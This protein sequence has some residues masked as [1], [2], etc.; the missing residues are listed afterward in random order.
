MDQART[1][2]MDEENT[3]EWG[4]GFVSA[5]NSLH[6]LDLPDSLLLKVLM[7][8]P[9]ES[10]KSVSLTC[11]RF[12]RIT[13]D[14]QLWKTLFQRDFKISR[15]HPMHPRACA[16]RTEY[17]RLHD[18]SPAEFCQ[19][20]TDHDDEVWHV[21]F[22]HDGTMFATC[23]K[24]GT[25][26]LWN[27]TTP[28]TLRFT[29]DMRSMM[30]SWTHISKF[31]KSD[32]LLLVSGCLSN[33]SRNGKIAIFDLKQEFR[34][35]CCI[36][37]KPFS[38][39]GAWYDENHIF[40]SISHRIDFF[41]TISA[42]WLAKATPE[43]KSDRKYARTNPFR[44]KHLGEYR[45]VKLFMVANVPVDAGQGLLSASDEEFA[46]HSREYVPGQ[47]SNPL[48]YQR[49]SCSPLV[50]GLA[51]TKKEDVPREKL[52]I[53]KF[54]EL[55]DRVGIKRMRED[56]IV[57]EED[58]AGGVDWSDTE[59][60][61]LS[62]DSIAGNDRFT[63]LDATINMSGRIVGMALSPDERYLYMNIQ[64]LVTNDEGG[65]PLEPLSFVNQMNTRVIDLVTY[66]EVG[67]VL[68]SHTGVTEGRFLIYLDVS[69]LYV[70]SGSHDNQ[71]YMW[72]R[73]YGVHVRCFPHSDAV[74]SCALNPRNSEMLVTA[75]DDNTIR[76]WRSRRHMRQ[77]RQREGNIDEN[78]L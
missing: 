19:E 50:P 7:S 41:E 75:S 66:T 45:G 6:L 61:L 42:V 9:L 31:N 3:E 27:A 37:V 48:S 51:E 44:F 20:L 29:A 15:S 34:V 10:V 63:V 59:V 43:V 55:S 8:L 62:A 18:E 11:L 65:E 21:T 54:G 2:T 5:G 28:C 53:F 60:S 67:A 76:I 36:P 35:M 24:D 17:R 13:C 32:S 4:E 23:S 25:V 1:S 12:N 14:E 78:P 22:S 16:W 47:N 56:E 39:F 64:R 58:M 57:K 74:N 68:T 70:A 77:M 52:L 38:A 33:T 26:K 40:T 46:V 71:G 72:D 30:W 73:H 69:Q 49:A